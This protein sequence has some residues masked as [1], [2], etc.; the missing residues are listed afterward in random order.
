MF[1][2]FYAGSLSVPSY[3]IIIGIG[4]I[5]GCVVCMA[6]SPKFGIGREDCLYA[7]LF[8]VIGVV[9]GGKILYI[10][11]DLPRLIENRAYFFGTLE[12]FT[13]L[14]GGGFVYYGGLFGGLLGAYVYTRMYKLR[15]YDFLQA[16]VPVIPLIH[17]IGRIGCFG[18]G[19]CYGIPWDPPVGMLFSESMAAPH[20][21]Y[22]FP[23][24]LLEAGLNF[25]L[26]AVLMVLFR[27]PRKLPAVGVYFVGY[28]IVRLICEYFRYDAER[29]FFLG[30]STSQWIS[31]LVFP[32]GILLIWMALRKT[33]LL[34]AG[35]YGVSSGGTPGTSEEIPESP[36][37]KEKSAEEG[38]EPESVS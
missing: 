4:F 38:Q 17:G 30:I 1:P 26:F 28:G 14:L 27:R 8:A 25:I 7:L 5:L 10:L 32:L 33:P 22:L 12:G 13:V 2:Y 3:G 9:V 20:D 11:S 15:F 31:L 6:R 16:V 23:V 36:V 18:A 21:V 29:G 19:C 37:S 24:Q 34:G 35:A